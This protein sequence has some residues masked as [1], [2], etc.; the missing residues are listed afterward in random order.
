[1]L[2]TDPAFSL[3]ASRFLPIALLMFI[4]VQELA[5]REASV[6]RICG[7]LA[8][9]VALLAIDGI[10]QSL[11]GTSLL[12]ASELRSDRVSASVPHPNDLAMIPILLPIIFALLT[13]SM[14]KLVKGLLWVTI[15]LAVTTAVL[16]QSRN[17][18]IGLATGLGAWLALIR[19][20]RVQIATAVAVVVVGAGA[21]IFDIGDV[22]GRVA[23]LTQPYAEGR[24]GIWLAAWEMFK[25]A[26]L[27]GQGRAHLRRA[28]PRVPGA[29]GA[30]RRVPAGG[31]AHPVG[32]QPLPGVPERA[33]RVRAGRVP[34]RGGGDGRSTSCGAWRAPGSPDVRAYAAGLAGWLAVF[35][36]MG[37]LDLTFFKDWVTLLFWVLLALVARLG[38]LSEVVAASGCE[39]RAGAAPRPAPPPT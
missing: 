36:A 35:L 16:S 30:A 20:R 26:P 27:L 4:A 9:V 19:R 2:S 7:T 10:Y 37:V 5:W 28:L 24:I 25:D 8:L 22:R 38:D 1:M 31:R 15:P 14:P 39:G 18:W 17:A 21:W 6:R 12:G 29:G 23:S 34:G 11:A 3:R 33:W 13:M 32:A